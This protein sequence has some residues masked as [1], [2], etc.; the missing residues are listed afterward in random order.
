MQTRVVGLGKPSVGH[1]MEST[2]ERSSEVK[3]PGRPSSVMPA[4]A[5]LTHSVTVA[6][7]RA[8]GRLHLPIRIGPGMRLTL[9]LSQPPSHSW[10]CRAS[11]DPVNQPSPLFTATCRRTIGKQ[12]S[13][14]VRLT[15]QFLQ[16]ASITSTA[17][18]RWR[19]HH[20]TLV[21]ALVKA[22]MLVAAS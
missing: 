4:Y 16:R 2:M 6:R 5:A 7:H 13:Y 15:H 18:L 20:P 11:Q 12:A 8:A 10:S 19:R 9:G 17:S 22:N 3:F 1:C 14:V 21:S